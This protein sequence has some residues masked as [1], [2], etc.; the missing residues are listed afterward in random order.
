M[1]SEPY[2]WCLRCG[3][4]SKKRVRNLAKA[5]VGAPACS[6]HRRVRELLAQGKHPVSGAVLN[7]AVRRRLT[8]DEWLEFRKSL[9]GGP[10]LD[11]DPDG[12]SLGSLSALE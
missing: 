8:V 1:L 6:Y 3:A 10:L 9:H 7:G 11:A 5:C 12:L 4:H 2:V